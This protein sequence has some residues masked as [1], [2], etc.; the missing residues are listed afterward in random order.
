MSRAREEGEE[1]HVDHVF[2]FVLFRSFGMVF[3]SCA[4]PKASSVIIDR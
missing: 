1:V 3:M 4:H 2:N